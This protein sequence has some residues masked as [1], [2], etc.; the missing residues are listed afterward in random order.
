MRSVNS[1]RAF[2]CP[3]CNLTGY[4]VGSNGME[5]ERVALKDEAS[6]YATQI[7][8]QNNG[9]ETPAKSS[10]VCNLRNS[11]VPSCELLTHLICYL[12]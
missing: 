6:A 5:N 10:E 1:D 3:L 11:A 7:I 8:Q 12:K 9:D 2:G 4:L